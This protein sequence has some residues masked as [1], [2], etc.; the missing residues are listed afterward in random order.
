ML[1]FQTWCLRPWV[2]I[3]AIRKVPIIHALY[4]NP[5]FSAA[6]KEKYKTFR[7]QLCL[8]G[9]FHQNFLIIYQRSPQMKW[10]LK[11]PVTMIIDAG[12]SV[13]VLLNKLFLPSQLK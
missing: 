2:S 5:F 1:L 3:Y 13:S 11:T 9:V 10:F 12:I 8:I 6:Q 4:F 7:R